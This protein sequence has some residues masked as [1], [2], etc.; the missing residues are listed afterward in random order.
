MPIAMTLLALLM[1]GAMFS[2]PEGQA[3]ARKWM[4]PLERRLMLVTVVT[5]VVI[6]ASLAAE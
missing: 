6:G 2:T 3:E 4:R 1:I 5:W